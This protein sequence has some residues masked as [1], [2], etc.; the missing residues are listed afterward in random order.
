[1]L[2]N[3]NLNQSKGSVASPRLQGGLTRALMVLM[4]GT[5]LS[6]LPITTSF[7]QEAA[8]EDSDIDTIVTLGSRRPG[9]SSSDV[10][11]PVDVISAEEIRAQGNTDI[12]NLLRTSIPS[13][14]IGDHPLSGTSTSVRP[15]TLRGLSPD[16]TL[17]LINGKRMHRA[18]DIPTFSGGISD[19]SQGPDLSSIPVMALK[20]VE[21]LRDGAAAQYGSDAIAGVINFEMNDSAE[22]A[23]FEVK[24]GSSYQGDGDSYQVGGTWGTQLGQTGF[25]RFTAEFKESELTDRSVQRGDA[26]ALR[27]AGNLDVP[28]P[29]TRFGTPQIKDDLKLFVNGA[30]EVGEGKEFYFFGGYS[31][32]KTASDF[33]YRNPT[34]RFGV[35]TDDD[36]GGNFL[37]G[38]MTPEDGNVCEGGIDFDG[39][40]LVNNPIGVGDV[41]AAARLA[42]VFADPNCYSALQQFPGGYTPFFGSQLTDASGTIGL[43]GELESGITYDISAAAG[44]NALKFNIDN[45]PNPSLGNLSPTKFDN[46]GKRIQSETNFNADFSYP[47]EIEGLYSPLNIATGVEWHR[48][49]FTVVAG[50]P[51][52]FE[53]GILADQGFLIGEEAFPGFSP[54][55]AGDFARSNFAVYLDLEADVTED[56]VLGAAVRFEDFT[57]MGSKATYKLTGLYHVT[58]SLGIRSSFATGFHAPTPGQQNFSALTT[59]ISGDGSL[60]ESGVIPPTSP[61]AIAV[62]GQQLKPETSKSFSLGF[63]YNTDYFNLTVDYFNIKMSDRL[64][65]SASQSLSADQKTAL[66]NEGFFAAAGLGSFRFF[67]NDFSTKT[68]GVDVVATIPLQVTDS[69]TTEVV[70][71]ANYTKT[72]VTSFD[73]TDPDELLSQSRVTQL[74][75]NNPKFRGNFT[76]RH[77]EENWGAHIRANY[78]SSFTELH[79]NAGSLQ[80]DAK[81]QITIDLQASYN[82]SE[83]VEFSIGADNV[84]N[85]FPTENPWDFIV[86]SKYP[87]TAPAGI[88]GGFYYAKIRLDF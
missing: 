53:A 7:A 3:K 65:Q 18:A 43:R 83:N 13:L 56:L 66:I 60:I 2:T 36:D 12:S 55:T 81:S 85:S 76:I 68:Q 31:E 30:A 24:Y 33:F 6:T 80:I 5:A 49:Q 22:G 88:L 59:E 87:T 16:H 39:T 29:A 69:G 73:P 77:R 70:F 62:G 20:R 38:D 86:G 74:E 40:G 48:E 23:S 14:N 82:I 61:V 35:F 11:V 51:A 42:N 34:G 45:V 57:D 41:D 63:I 21:V 47:L 1:M 26:A 79:V 46:L 58:E 17:V 10:P 37:I 75:D 64:T 44:R 32:R 67:T 4:S 84:F 50:E 72:E 15:P 8:A 27:A 28:E 78:F 25:L 52:S 54:T 19:G 9:R 71:A